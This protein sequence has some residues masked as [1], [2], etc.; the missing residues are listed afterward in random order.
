MISAEKRE[1]VKGQTVIEQRARELVRSRVLEGEE[2]RG[3]KMVMS[4][5]R[6]TMVK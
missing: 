3:T 5:R 2:G 6:E 1:K 4:A